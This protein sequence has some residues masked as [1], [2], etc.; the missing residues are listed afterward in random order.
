M[1]RCIQVESEGPNLASRQRL[2]REFDA[3]G[4]MAT[5]ANSSYNELVIEAARESILAG[6]RMVEIA[7]TMDPEPVASNP[8]GF[9]RG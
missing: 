3:A 8:G 4:L 6:G 9:P 2:L 1:Q 5:P 7:P